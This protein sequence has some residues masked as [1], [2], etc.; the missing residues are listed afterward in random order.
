MGYQPNSLP[1][2]LIPQGVP[3]NRTGFRN[4]SSLSFLES[5][6]AARSHAQDSITRFQDTFQDAQNSKRIALEFDIGDQVLINPHSLRLEGP[7]GGKGRKF[8]ERYEGPFEVTEKYGPTTYGIRLPADYN[9]HSVINIEHLVP[10]HASPPEYGPRSVRDVKNR[11]ETNKEDWEVAEIVEEKYST[12]K[13]KGRRRLLYRCKWVY[14]DGTERETDEWIPERDMNNAREV[15]H[16]WK[17]KITDSPELK[18]R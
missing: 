17:I 18:A 10:Y 14:P 16:S 12:R 4:D 9:I 11:T 2:F 7:W 15:L 1:T 5:I 3:Q 6:Q 8:A 13:V